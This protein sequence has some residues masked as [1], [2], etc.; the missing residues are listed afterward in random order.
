M[1][2][3]CQR[4]RGQVVFS[5]F[6]DPEKLFLNRAEPDNT[7]KLICIGRVTAAALE[8]LGLKADVTAETYDIRGLAEAMEVLAEE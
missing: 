3:I 1:S 8:S 6:Q 2:G 4:I 7:P 5:G